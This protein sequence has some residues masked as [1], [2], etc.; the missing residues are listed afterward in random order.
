MSAK[1]LSKNK[2]CKDKDSNMNQCM[3]SPRVKEREN[4]N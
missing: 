3:V 4:E 2:E 1:L